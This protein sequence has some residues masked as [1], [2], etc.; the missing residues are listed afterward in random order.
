MID[1]Q[2]RLISIC[3]YVSSVFSIK[4]EYFHNLTKDQQ[5]QILDYKLMVYLCDGT[6]SERLDY[7]R[8]INLQGAELTPQELRNAVYTGTWLSNA[9]DY[10]SKPKGLAYNLAS[11]YVDGSP[12]RQIYLE[13]ALKWI[14]NGKI[15]AYMA[16]HQHDTDAKELWN[17]FESVIKWV[18]RIFTTYR[19]EMKGLEWGFLY[20]KY[21]DIDVDPAAIEKE[22]HRLMEDEDVGKKSGIYLYLLTGD[23]KRLRIRGFSPKTKREVYE[24]QRGVCP[25]CKGEFSFGA[26][27]G[28]HILPWCK[29]GKTTPENCQMLCIRCNRTKR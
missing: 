29:G 2:Q 25:I 27:E 1:G 17:Y 11:R 26:M 20:N 14:N 4:D 5:Q 22:V 24:R 19:S 21:K 8:K 9:K 6:D 3:Q 12:I 23:E 28:D 15:D 18:E 7:F 13:T 10:F 16:E